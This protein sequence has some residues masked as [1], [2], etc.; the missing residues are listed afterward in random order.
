MSEGNPAVGPGFAASGV[1]VFRSLVEPELCREVRVA[2]EPEFDRHP[3]AD[4]LMD[5]WR[6]HSPVREVA[7][8]PAVMELLSE[9]YGRRPIP[10]QTLDFRHGTE[11]R[12]HADSVHFDSLP[13]GLMCGVWVAL[14]DVGEDQGPLTYVPGSHLRPRVDPAAARGRG[15]RFDYERYEDLEAERVRGMATERFLAHAGDALVWAADLVHGGAPRTDPTSTR[16]S[17]VTHYFFE[18]ATYVTPMLG[19]PVTGTHHVREPLIDIATGGTVTHRVDGA[20]ARI[21]RLAG[22]R[23]RV[24][25]PDDPRPGPLT[26]A[27]SATRGA[28]RIAS[29]RA[30]TALVRG[31]GWS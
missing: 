1:A 31:R 8:H 12:L 28:V 9:L 26:R 21:M 20:P 13:P 15:G 29:R 11:Q 17:Q 2:L 22:G 3:G 19:D 10:F 25:G 24:L 18:G 4:R 27:V 16:W 30:M 6:R 5:M 23:S 14:E 7:R